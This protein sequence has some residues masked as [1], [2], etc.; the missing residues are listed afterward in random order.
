ME[1]K[2]F[3][4]ALLKKDDVVLE[5]RNNLDKLLFVIPELKDMI[6]FEHCHPHHHLNV[7]EHT[8]LALQASPN[9]LEIRLSLLLHDIGKPFSYQQDG[10][11]RH[12]QGHAK[13]SAMIAKSIFERLGFEELFTD[14]VIE[15]IKRHDTPLNEDDIVERPAFSKVL[16]EVQKCDALA[17]NPAYNQK[18]IA[19]INQMQALLGLSNGTEA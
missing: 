9:Q 16:F 18:R 8:L 17:H 1:N 14:S 10:A 4:I 5:I 12:Y 7:W 13:K 11:V 15:I 3:L 19:Y 6:G 2:D